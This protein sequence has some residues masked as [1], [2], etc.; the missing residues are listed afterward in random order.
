MTHA[1]YAYKH[2]RSKRYIFISIGRKRIEKVVDFIPLK[3]KRFMNLGFGDLL[4]DGSIDYRV[5][6]NNGD[7]IKVLATV[8]DILRHFMTLHP[9]KVIYFR[10]STDERTKLYSRIIRTYY[11]TFSKEFEIIGIIGTIKD[12]STIPFDPKMDLEY[13]AFLIRRI[14]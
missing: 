13:W 1:P 8:V 9:Q 7:I 5:N 10:G 14:A 4:P 2:V 3:P 6:S 11:P 12:N